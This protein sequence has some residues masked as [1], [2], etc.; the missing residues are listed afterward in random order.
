MKPQLLFVFLLLSFVGKAQFK[1]FAIGG[2]FSTNRFYTPGKSKDP[3]TV[4]QPNHYYSGGIFVQWN[5]RNIVSIAVNPLIEKTTRNYLVENYLYN[6]DSGTST[7]CLQEWNYRIDRIALPILVRATFGKKIFFSPYLGLA[8]S[9]LLSTASSRER[10]YAK[11]S[12]VDFNH[13]L[14]ESYNEANTK[15]YNELNTFAGVGLVIPVKENFLIFADTRFPIDLLSYPRRA[16][17]DDYMSFYKPTLSIGLGYQ[18]NLKKVSSYEFS[19]F[20]FRLAKTWDD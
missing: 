11:T 16:D 18:F 15:N 9:F 13:P 2:T 8:Y 12:P 14:I 5:S 19:T 20:H 10:Y 4:S 7:L 6:I 1:R 17:R 3:E